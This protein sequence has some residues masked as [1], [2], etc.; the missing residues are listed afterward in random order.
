[1]NLIG[2]FQGKL[3]LQTIVVEPAQFW[4]IILWER[5]SHVPHGGEL[6]ARMNECL[7]TCL[8]AMAGCGGP[9][10]QRDAQPLDPGL[11]HHRLPVR[12]P[13]LSRALQAQLVMRRRERP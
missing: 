9:A 6:Y 5:Q 1:M 4:P 3:A 7:L 12:V 10:L 11:V 2:I 13:D 8:C